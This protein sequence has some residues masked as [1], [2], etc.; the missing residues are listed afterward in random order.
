MTRRVNRLPHQ[1]F[2]EATSATA[3]PGRTMVVATDGTPSSRTA[4]EKDLTM[5]LGR[6]ASTRLRDRGG[7]A[8]ERDCSPG[9]GLEMP[10]SSSSARVASSAS[11]TAPSS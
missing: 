4:V 6:S 1:H 3:P 9:R 11:P 7:K 5:A 8:G 2:R 10:I